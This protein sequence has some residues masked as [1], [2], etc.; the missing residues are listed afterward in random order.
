MLSN[1]FIE[2]PFKYRTYFKIF[3]SE[4]KP[5]NRI[6][7][8]PFDLGSADRGVEGE[9]IAWRDGGTSYPQGY[10]FTVAHAYQVHRS[11]TVALNTCYTLATQ[12]FLMKMVRERKF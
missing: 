7:R 11:G 1:G 5:E 8:L 3:P 12:G 10:C 6:K 4:R 2:F 9:I